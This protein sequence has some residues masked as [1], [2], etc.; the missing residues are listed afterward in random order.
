MT[1]NPPSPKRKLVRVNPIPA[2]P[3]PIISHHCLP[4]TDS[5]LHFFCVS[6]DYTRNGAIMVLAPRA[7]RPTPAGISICRPWATLTTA[8]AKGSSGWVQAVTAALIGHPHPSRSRMVPCR[9]SRCTSPS[10]KSAWML[11]T[12]Y[13]LILSLQFNRGSLRFRR[14]LKRGCPPQSCTCLCTG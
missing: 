2:Y 6:F 10:R 7:N 11:T 8:P 13:G 5:I 3:L 14:N 12:V 1:D 9:P 4:S